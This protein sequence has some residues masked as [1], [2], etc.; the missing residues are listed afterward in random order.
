MAL[1]RTLDQVARIR[2][3]V[4]AFWHEPANF[5]RSGGRTALHAWTEV[6]ILSN[7]KFVF[8]DCTFS[9]ERGIET[10]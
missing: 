8:H 9:Y 7:S 10:T 2:P 4:V 3:G 5:V 1:S 6:Y